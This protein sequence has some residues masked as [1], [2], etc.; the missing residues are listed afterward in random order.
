MTLFREIAIAM[1]VLVVALLAVTMYSS[2]QTNVRFIEDQLYTNAKNTASSLGL[3]IS[4]TSDGKDLAMAE[5]MINAVFDS[6]LYEAIVYRDI[7][8]KV[9]YERRMP[10]AIGTVPAWFAEAIKLPPAAAAVPVGREWLLSGD[11]SIEGHRGNAYAQM[12]DAFK[13][14]VSSFIVLSVLAMVGIYFLLKIVLRALDKVR[15]QAEAVSGSRFII[16]KNLPHTKEFRDVVQAMNLLVY[17]VKEIYKQEA[18][19][20]ARYN[21]MLYEDRQTRLKNRD[22]F[23]MKLGSM[24]S[25]EDRFSEGYIVAIRFNDPERVK[26]EQG[27]YVLQK[28][29]SHVSD[30]ARGIVNISGDGFACRVREY[31]IMLILPSISEDEAAAVIK[32]MKSDCLVGS[33]NVTI[34]ATAYHAVEKTSEVLSHVDYALMQAEAHT[35]EDA[36][37]YRP[38]RDDIPSWGHDEWRR[39]LIDAM[40]HD[41]FVTLFQPIMERSGGTVQHELLLR[42]KLDTAFLSAGA[43]IPVVSHLELEN[44]LDRYVLGTL[45]RKHH[46]TEIAVNVSGEFIRHSSTMHW[47]SKLQ[48]EWKREAVNVAFEV[49]NSTVLEDTEAAEAFSAFAQKLGWRFGIDHF[50]IEEENLTYLQKIKPSYLKIDAAYLLSLIGIQAETK[51][52]PALFTIARLL[53]IDLI[54]TGVDKKETAERLYEHGIKMLQGFWVGKPT[55]EA[56]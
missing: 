30:I 17:K 23:M 44:K 51:R 28:Q 15:E 20:V 16:Q 3:A 6:G 35:K 12:W 27:A 40:K 39:R 7:D 47:L 41:R 8:G 22:F 10:L 53:D 48:S 36:F 49:S 14:V 25:S 4:R 33:C 29:L 13:N 18:D 56:R 31:D 38:K 45:G 42:L 50:V 43:F 2:Y 21:R 26:T 19:A 55:G 34:A 1:S 46:A 5:T 52:D 37:V 11:L 32:E 9:L 24:L 54:A